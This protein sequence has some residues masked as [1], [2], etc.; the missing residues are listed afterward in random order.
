MDLDELEELITK[1]YTINSEEALFIYKNMPLEQLLALA[2]NLSKKY[3]AKD[4][5]TCSIIN[6]RSGKCSEDCKWC[7]QSKFHNTN[8]EIYSLLDGQKIIE[9]AQNNANNGVGRF[10]LVTSGRKMSTLEIN[11]IV[12]VYEHL[13]DNVKIELC[14]SMGLLTK[15]ELQK[16]YDAGCKRY[17]CN[18]E[19]APS[20]FST[21][22]STHTIED[23]IKTISYAKEVGMTICSGGIIGMGET[24]E[25]RIEMAMLLREL[26]VDSIPMNVLNP[27]KGTPLENSSPLSDE[28]ILRTL[29]IFKVIYPKAVIRF[30]GG[31]TLITQIQKDAVLGG[32]SAA[33]VGDMLTTLGIDM[34][35]DLE[36]LK[37]LRKKMWVD[38]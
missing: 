18:L 25:Q 30:A 3:D 38:Q 22:C 36:M 6:A 7:S 5:D 33:I 15:V 14:A 4:F 2:R 11:K 20:H 9:M 19:T 27:I 10:S 28:D 17:H 35:T 29:A 37:S 1:E 32:V 31:R 16:L 26:K 12:P 23:K 21:L 13:R 8:I 24:A 34:K